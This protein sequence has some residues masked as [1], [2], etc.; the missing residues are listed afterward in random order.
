MAATGTLSVAGTQ[1]VEHRLVTLLAVVA[2]AVESQTTVS[3]GINSGQRI[4]GSMTRRSSLALGT[5]V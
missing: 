2:Q 3:H 4:M 1:H 5:V